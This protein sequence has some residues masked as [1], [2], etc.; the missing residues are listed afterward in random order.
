M[1]SIKQG[2]LWVE[3]SVVSFDLLHTTDIRL[4]KLSNQTIKVQIMILVENEAQ[5]HKE[6]VL[7][8][9]QLHELRSRLQVLDNTYYEPINRPLNCRQ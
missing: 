1:F 5:Y 9:H 8:D 3:N 7:Q 4:F 2:R 6:H